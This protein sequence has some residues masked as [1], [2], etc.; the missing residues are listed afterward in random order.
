MTKKTFKWLIGIIIL[1]I[2]LNVASIGFILFKTMNSPVST[3]RINDPQAPQ[4]DRPFPDMMMR[5]MDFSDDQ[6]SELMTE[7]RMHRQEMQMLND[8]VQQIRRQLFL[9]NQSGDTNSGTERIQFYE[10][11]GDLH[12]KM[13]QLQ[14]EHIRSL[15]E[16]STPKQQEQLRNWLQRMGQSHMGGGPRGQQ[17]PQDG[18]MHRER[19]GNRSDR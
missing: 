10:R 6:R 17:Q 16:I 4:M 1:L 13:I 11:A 8:S 9:M 14:D 15:M 19:R 7:F 2:V 5:R 3:L 18:M 12:Q